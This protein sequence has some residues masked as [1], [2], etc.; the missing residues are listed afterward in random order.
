MKTFSPVFILSLLAILIVDFSSQSVAQ[1]AFSNTKAAALRPKAAVEADESVEM[2][3]RRR[4]KT[5]SGKFKIVYETVQLDPKKTAVI[6]CDMWDTL[7]CP[8]TKGRVDELASPMNRVVEAARK[9]GML[10]VHSPSGTLGP[11]AD[12]PGRKAVQA[13]PVVKTKVPL[14][15]WRKLDPK[16]EPALPIDDE[17]GWGSP[18]PAKTPPQ[19]CQHP[20]IR[21]EPGD[22]IGDNVDVYYFLE[23][24]GIENVILMGVHTNRCI[25]GRPFGIRQLTYQGKKVFLM[26]DMTDSLYN[27]KSRPFV[28][29]VRGTELVLEHI[30]KYWCPTVTSTDLTGD[31]A[32]R[33]KEDDRPHV[34]VMVSDDHYH[35]DKTL[36]VFAQKLREEYGCH[37]TVLHGQHEAN[38]PQTAELKKADLVVLY[39]RRLVLPKKQLSAL[40]NYLDAG[41]PLVALRT[42]SHAFAGHYKYPEGYQTPEGR[43]EWPEFD[44]EVLGGNYHNH[45]KGELGTDVAE[46]AVAAGHPIL[47]GVEPARWHSVGS[48][49]RTGPVAEDATLLQM[50]S[51][52]GESHPLTWV[53]SHRSGRVFYTG[54]GHPKDFE[55]PAFETLLVNAIFW[56]MDREVPPRKSNEEFEYTP[57][58]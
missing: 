45:A 13:A 8:I 1:T 17:W 36:P 22:G 29:H 6:I 23:H 47:R 39:V 58:R 5:D 42:A 35:A 41:K 55:V 52:L 38:L 30:E 49:Y 27:P 14:Y 9:K 43:D 44:A 20:A 53:R 57:G 26:R 40:R 2:L 56:A 4:E 15:G 32:V 51:I 10:I 54:L 33:L 19:S 18:P 50:G 28:N 34:V 11:Y 24:K 16:R 21:I 31:P 25:L 37:V 48:L 46:V 3:T 7:W 12:H